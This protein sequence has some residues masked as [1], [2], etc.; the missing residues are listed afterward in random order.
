MALA[1]AVYLSLLGKQGLRQ[2]AELCYQK[3]HY[4]AKQIATAKGFKVRSATP[5]F[6]EFIV[7]CP[8][9]VAELNAHLLGHGVLGGYDLSNDYPSLKNSMLVAVTEMNSKDDIDMFV[10]LLKEPAHD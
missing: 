2:V 1:S 6:H 4:A 10:D 8:M 5:F 9:P 3:A 7:E